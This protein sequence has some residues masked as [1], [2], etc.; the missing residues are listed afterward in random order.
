MA[1]FNE[2][3]TSAAQE[4]YDFYT[5]DDNRLVYGGNFGADKVYIKYT[6]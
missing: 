3:Y 2:E 6:I 5:S 4:A 1:I